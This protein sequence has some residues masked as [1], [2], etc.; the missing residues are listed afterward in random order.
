MFRRLVSLGS[1]TYA[2]VPRGVKR[3]IFIYLGV[4]AV[5][6]FLLGILVTYSSTGKSK[7]LSNDYYNS[8]INDYDSNSRNSFL[9]GINVQNIR[10]TVK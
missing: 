3:K 6:S 10:E 4:T 2:D 1:N 5:V 7:T 9:S 8:L